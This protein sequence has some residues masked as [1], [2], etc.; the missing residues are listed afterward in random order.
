MNSK[1]AFIEV[2]IGKIPEYFR[3]HIETLEHISCADFFFFTDDKDY[4]FS[5]IRNQNFHLK[6]INESEF[7]ERFNKTSEI[8]IE[9]ISSPKKIIDFKLSYF[10]MFSDYL[11]D[12]GYVGIYDIDTL[13]GDM[14]KI[15]MSYLG[16]FDFISVGDEIYH[17]RLSGPMMIFRNDKE[18]KDTI[19]TPRYYETLLSDEVYG[20]G[21]QELSTIAF[22]DYKVKIIYSMNTETSNGGKNTFDVLWEG[23]KLK[24]NDE[25]K[26]FYHFYRK[27]HTSFKKVGNKIYG[28]YDK[29]YLNDFY[30]V[31]G[32]TEN[33][34]HTVKY[35]MNSIHNYSN[36]KCIIYCINFDYKIPDKFLTSE[37]FIVRRIDIEQGNKDYRGRDENI[38]SC[39]PKI[40]IDVLNFKFGSRF[41]FI[42]SDV[43][44]TTSADD[45]CKYFD[46]LEHYPLINSHTHDKLYLTN[47]REGEEWTST[48]DVLADRLGVEVCVFPR[49]K[50]NIMLFDEKSRWFF[51]EQI[52]LYENHKGSEAGI[53]AFH[54]EDSA[55]LILSKYKLMNSLHL[56]DVE[57]SDDIDMN[58]FT[59]TNHPFHMTELSSFLE[60]P[61][62]KNDIVFFHGMKDEN[63]YKNIEKLYGNTVLDCEE[64]IVYMRGDSIFFEKNSFLSTKKIDENVDFIVK[65]NEGKILQV[66]ENQN[67][68]FYWM[69]YLSNVYFDK[70]LYIIEIVKSNTKTKIYNNL[71]EI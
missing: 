41:I 66:L 20:Y 37:Q 34:S 5:K 68:N 44:L 2:W 63:R 25:E 8:K 71:V 32:F 18:I 52:E 3:Y 29:K 1:I 15:L 11:Q 4:D 39:K 28:R 70:G 60:L 50:T 51:E 27:N 61:K 12:Y 7:L 22:R 36:R 58:K 45:F 67:L 6:Y 16:E 21:E 56:C 42:D 48:I 69:F 33:Y 9:K 10:D 19:K 54:D 65:N 23:G 47:L 17:N 40:M 53:F 14:N 55:N 46:K 64:I 31:F 26:L 30:W 62:H 38:I 43:Y 49:R 35:L 24:I 57:E 13:F 59:D